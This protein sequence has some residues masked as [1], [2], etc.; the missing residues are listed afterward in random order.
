M[1]GSFQWPWRLD[2][3][4][5]AALIR[6]QGSS[7]L[8]YLLQPGRDCQPGP[9]HPD[10]EGQ[11]EHNRVT[12]ML[13]GSEHVSG[14]TPRE[15]YFNLE[16]RLLLLSTQNNLAPAGTCNIVAATSLMECSSPCSPRALTVANPLLRMGLSTQIWSS[17]MPGLCL[18]PQTEGCLRAEAVSPMD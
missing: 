3:H 7:L 11:E 17:L 2:S 12:S 18:L 1:A 5:H 10:W 14:M 15:S 9:G 6:K 16:S 8:S 4:F 13:L